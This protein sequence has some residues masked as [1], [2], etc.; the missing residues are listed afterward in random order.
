MAEGAEAEWNAASFV[1]LED[2][3]PSEVA[4][5]KR[6]RA[7]SP[8]GGDIEVA[9]PVAPPRPVSYSSA[10]SARPKKK[11]NAGTSGV[12]TP[13]GYANQFA[14]EF[15]FGDPNISRGSTPAGDFGPFGLAGDVVVGGSAAGAGAVASTSAAYDLP[16]FDHALLQAAAAEVLGLPRAHEP[17]PEPEQHLDDLVVND[18]P[19]RAPRARKPRSNPKTPGPKP[20]IKRRPTTIKRV[21][22]PVRLLPDPVLDDIDPLEDVIDAGRE[23]VRAKGKDRRRVRVSRLD[24]T[25][26]PEREAEAELRRTQRRKM[27]QAGERERQRLPKP[28]IPAIFTVAGE[29]SAE[30]KAAI[31]RARD[32]FVLLRS[33]E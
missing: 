23:Y 15:P 8:L 20:P 22:V 18:P 12:V 31:V 5:G 2:D 19:Q 29:R 14:A 16:A 24:G 30:A 17:E 4:L 28:L 26:D 21:P 33:I 25:P 13:R 11:L 1:A 9:P 27:K 3:A 6:P 10:F 7:R 32:P